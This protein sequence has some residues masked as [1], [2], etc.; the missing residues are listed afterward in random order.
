LSR[1]K[2]RSTTALIGLLVLGGM[3]LGAQLSPASSGGALELDR[4]LQQLGE[5]RRVLLIGAHPDD[6][7]TELLAFL[8]Q[9][10]GADAAYLSLSRGE[11]GQN[12][13]GTELGIG[14]GLLR[15]QE[16]QAARREDGARQ[17]FTRAYDFG[18]SG[19]LDETASYWLPDSI[20]K[21]V[22]RVVR[23]FRP[24]V[25]VSVFS[26]TARVGHGQHQMAGLLA[27]R[28]F[29]AAADPTAY[30]GLAVDEGLD[31]WQPLKLYQ[32]YRLDPGIPSVTLETG[33]LDPR[34]G[35]SYHQIAMASRSQH[36]SQDM[37][38]LQDI[39]PQRSSL[40]L[41]FDRTAT[42]GVELFAGIP[43]DTSWLQRFADSLR[44]AIAPVRVA[45]AAA[46]VARALERARR[47]HLPLERQVLLQRALATAGGLV[48]DA[49]ASEGTVV[50]GGEVE[51][52]LRL[53][54]GG[55]RRVLAGRTT[56]WAPAGWEQVQ[57]D[58]GA[59]VLP[60]A[61]TVLRTKVAVPS[62]ARVTQPYYLREPMRGALYSWEDAD[63][64]VWGE[65]LQPGLLRAG[66]T[67]YVEG[68]H[69]RV[70]RDVTY[71]YNDQAVGEVRLP[72]RV[73]PAIDVRIE[74]RVLLWP[75]D[76]PE[77]QGFS[78]IVTSNADSSITGEVALRLS[79][80]V[81]PPAQPFVLTA[82]GQTQTL[83]FVIENQAEVE[84]DTVAIAVVAR[85]SDGSEYSGAVRTIAYDHIDPVSFLEPARA[86]I[87]AAPIR[88]PDD[89]RVGYVR[90]AA[91]R[92]PEA[93]MRLGFDVQLLDEHALSRG[94]LSIYDVIVIGSRAYE[95]TS[96]LAQHNGR[97]LAYVRAGGHLVV[98]YQQYQFVAGDF[99][100]YRLQIRRPHD[101]VTD[102]TV[103][104]TVMDPDHPVFRTP[105]RIEDADWLAWPQ[106]RGLYF[107]GEWDPRYLPL[108]EMADPGTPPLRGG[109]L[110][111]EYGEGTYVY[112][113]LSFF[114]AIP[115][116]TPG[117]VRLF[118]NL[119]SYGRSSAP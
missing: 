27:R 5:N 14:L 48:F 69:L 88:S 2:L 76:G 117:A 8:V 12:L 38:R 34:T 30:P 104:V 29:D 67:V 75:T 41:L 118:V 106:E 24:H 79:R 99:A 44:N 98:Q 59:E 4:L 112:T 47:E 105:N 25:V 42:G 1:A 65:P 113:G 28:A 31:P 82:R 66:M 19:S 13:I 70:E 87:R 39:G 57:I 91:D 53:Y 10:L 68:E 114:R 71:R 22:V 96:A 3:P 119:L 90:G 89:L 6:E 40:G 16:L 50:P 95:T 15:T 58:P 56:I 51:V 7:D 35:R 85:T 21:D 18:Y 26:P 72:L 116:G 60:G 49:T 52:T 33:A 101:R 84:R 61:V 32:T 20:L 43:R 110:V 93:L 108:L 73:V 107:A 74:P 78:V 37:G 83:T 102:E 103:P 55:P 9:G 81:G 46:P 54:N 23:R 94:D 97:L 80:W 111:A 100:P 92:V 11:G 64:S 109:L 62:D 45:N 115:T 77:E 63:R 86:V 36:R 17:F